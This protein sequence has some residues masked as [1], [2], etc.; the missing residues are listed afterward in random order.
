[1]HIEENVQEF[2]HVTESLAG[3]VLTSISNL[4][5]VQVKS[6][7]RANVLYLRRKNTPKNTE[8]EDFAPGVHFQEI[9]KADFL[10]LLVLFFRCLISKEFHN[11]QTILHAHSTWS[12]FILRT[13]AIL[14][15]IPNLHYTPHCYAFKREDVH[16]LVKIM[17]W[18][19]EMVLTGLST[20]VTVGCCDT[21]A[22]E[23]LKLKS[24]RTIAGKNFVAVSN[25]YLRR[26]SHIDVTVATVGRISRQKNPQRFLEAVRHFPDNWKVAWY[27]D[28]DE[29]QAELLK[30]QNVYV[31]GWLDTSNLQVAY[32]EMDY[33]VL[34]SD[35]E[36]LPFSL[37]EAMSNGVIPI[38]WSYFGASEV[39]TNNQNGFIISDISEISRIILNLEKEDAQ[40]TQISMNAWNYVLENHSLSSLQ[41]HWRQYY[42]FEGGDQGQ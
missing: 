6:G 23:A 9:G 28:G 12:G 5:S 20:A 19:I 27:G 13:A 7:Y 29:S 30:S 10:G 16:R 40:K 22:Q 15:P 34:T 39:I 42:S 1:M 36:G 41:T 18:T 14:R 3:G 11:K 37:L 38:V 35:W 24:K 21:E 32:K 26:K 4:A 17:Y 25:S 31:S 33:F 2:L 8:L